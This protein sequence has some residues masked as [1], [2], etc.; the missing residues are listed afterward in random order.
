M[1]AEPSRQTYGVP[2]AEASL[3]FVCRRLDTGES[4]VHELER[5]LLC[6]L[7][8]VSLSIVRCDRVPIV[9]SGSVQ[10]GLGQDTEASVDVDLE[11][12]GDAHVKVVV[13]HP[14]SVARQED[15]DIDSLEEVAQ[16]LGG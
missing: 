6:L 8:C 11:R 3:D 16:S 10:V 2:E 9:E 13:A 12:E 4:L 15:V 5:R 7:D 14:P 1:S